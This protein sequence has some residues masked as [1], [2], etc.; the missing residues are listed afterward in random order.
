MSGVPPG[1]TVTVVG[2]S[3]SIPGPDSAASCYLVQAEDGD[4][5][6]SVVLDLGGGA[7]GALHRYL[8]PLTLDAVLLSHLHPDHC[9]DLTGLY[10]AHRHRPGQAPRRAGADRTPVYGPVRTAERMGRAYG[11][12][13]AE[14]LCAV[15]DFRELI[16][17]DRIRIG[18]LTIL[19]VAVH[20]PVAA[21][22][23]RVEAGGAVAVYTGDTDD[24]PQ[25]D[26]LMTGADLVLADSAFVEGRDAQEG[27]HLSA[28]RAA[29]AAIRAGG[30]RRLVLTHQPPWNDPEVSL[31]EARALWDGSL[32]LA[33]PG[34]VWHL[35]EG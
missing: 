30:V 26:D 35:P 34:A 7:L 33:A 5:T 9:L 22:G 23:F 4:R 15:F 8:D 20:H 25:L 18:P 27:V 13:R 21:F 32:E 6:W 2:C 19:P 1:L 29:R 12:D 14:D 28:H 16:D 11:A 31:A 10:V 3:G 17:S 24:C